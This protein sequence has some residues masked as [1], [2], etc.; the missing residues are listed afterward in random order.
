MKKGLEKLDTLLF[1]KKKVELVIANKKYALSI[2]QNSATDRK[3]DPIILGINDHNEVKIMVNTNGREDIEDIVQQIKKAFKEYLLHMEE[4][5]KSYSYEDILF[6]DED[7]LHEYYVEVDITEDHLL[8]K[9]DQILKLPYHQ[10][11][12]IYIERRSNLYQSNRNSKS[13]AIQYALSYHNWIMIE[14][15][16]KRYGF[17]GNQVEQMFAALSRAFFM[18]QLKEQKKE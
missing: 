18:A 3:I 17:S 7:S 11:N 13:N 12:D 10:I 15:D 16:D 14:T 8:I 1:N 5:N 9:Q 4:E 2:N 6:K